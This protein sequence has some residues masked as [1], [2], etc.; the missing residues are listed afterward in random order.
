MLSRALNLRTTVA[1]V[2]AGCSA[3]L[4]YPT[5]TQLAGDAVN[6][7]TRALARANK[8]SGESM[9]TL[10]RLQQRFQEREKIP[11]EERPKIP[12]P[13]L[14][15]IFGL[16]ERALSEVSEEKRGKYRRGLAARF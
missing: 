12:S 9:A 5:W 1:F 15:H 3:D 16:C 10:A 13:D 8:R 6:E 2:G 14:L 11:L 7:A 4:G